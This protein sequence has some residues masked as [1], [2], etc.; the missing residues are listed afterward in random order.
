M[1]QILNPVPNSKTLRQQAFQE[2][3][4]RAMSGVGQLYAENLQKQKTKR[5]QAFE[6]IQNAISLRNQGYDVTPEQLEQI[7]Q[8]NSGGLSSIFSEEKPVDYSGVL[9]KR[10]PEYLQSIEDK[11]IE[12]EIQKQRLK[13]L[14][15]G[16]YS[17]GGGKPAPVIGYEPAE[18]N[19]DITKQDVETVKKS[20]ATTK[21]VIDGVNSLAEKI[22]K[23]GFSS[24][25]GLTKSDIA[26]DSDIADLQLEMKNLAE[27]GAIAGPDLDLVNSSLGVLS[28]PIDK[29]N[30]LISRKDAIDQL[31]E[32]ANKAINRSKNISESRG[33]RRKG[34]E[35]KFKD[36]YENKIQN[37]IKSLT[38]E[39][40]IRLLEGR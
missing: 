16:K 39:E 4:D 26:I 36:P 37:E 14:K 28:G 34:E 18:Q 19:A 3:L 12:R 15:R 40:K 6:N 5:Q 1:V 9:S 24:G 31:K 13:N 35:L 21:N 27:L 32:V 10:T 29:L 17:A 11:K 38:R 23:F 30:P 22:K 33:L 8:Q 2:G 25:L 20:E 7:N